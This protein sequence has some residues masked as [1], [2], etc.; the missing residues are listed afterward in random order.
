MRIFPKREGLRP[1][2]RRGRIARYFLNRPLPDVVFH[3]DPHY[4]SG[5]RLSSKKGVL[6]SRRVE[7]L[8]PG[9]LRPSS[10]RSN[11]LDP[12][13]LK[14]TLAEVIRHL[15]L[16]GGAAAILLP[17]FSARVFILSADSL[18]SSGK[19]RE[20]FV[21]WRLGKTVPLPHEDI[22]IAFQV[23]RGPGPG[24]VICAMSRESIIREYEDLVSAAGLKV[25]TVTTPSLCLVNLLR[26]RDDSNGIIV[27]LEEDS[28]S[29][30]AVKGPDWSLFRQKGVTTGDQTSA[31]LEGKVG[32]VVKE[33]ENT[34]LFL[35]DKE[36][37]KVTKLWV[38]AGFLDGSGEVAGELRRR[39]SL[40]VDGIDT[41]ISQD[42]DAGEK[43]LLAPL[44][45]LVS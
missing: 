41:L 2:G 39:L 9:V 45:G 26:G 3:I 20:E 4:L 40:P 29:F 23:S 11:V 44:I 35:E 43:H 19:E 36:K 14:D 37:R 5:I 42:W 22:R 18:P 10:D 15:G 24:R 30:L 6:I 12:A 17:D 16:E 38:R 27:N 34:I 1:R 32:Q 28:L 13:S 8:P 7:P 25:G 31:P 21:R 33:V